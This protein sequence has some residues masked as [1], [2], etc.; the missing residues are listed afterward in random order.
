MKCCIVGAGSVGGH[1]AVKL[2]RAG[3][4]VSVLARG[5]QLAAIRAGGL[6]LEQDGQ[7]LAATVR[8]SD[9][10]AELGAQELVFVTTK[11]T[12]L[13]QVARQLPPLVDGATTVAFLQN[14]M[15]WW[16]PLGLPADLPT[17]PQLPL[18]RLA[19][20]YL[21]VLRPE[22][23]LGG[24][25]YSANEVLRPGVVRN[26]S[27]R[28]NLVELAAIDDRETP[29]VQR[30]RAVLVEAGIASP[31]VDDIRTAL[32]L[33]LVG[34]AS[35]S[36]L[37]VATGNPASLVQDP[38]LKT[39]Y[40]RL[41][42][43]C[44]AVAGASGYP[45]A[46]RMDLALFTQHRGQHKPSMLQDYEAGRP[47]EIEEIILA[48]VHFARAAGIATPTLDAAS[49]ITARLAADRGLFTPG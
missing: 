18:F 23:V 39:V 17:P 16:Y 35:A 46:D 22:Q 9:D 36:S 20:T 44:M 32:W 42:Q 45:V 48:P 34:N 28:R 6:V 14:G 2:Q 40:L 41:L 1:L 19:D 38:A 31:V 27:P 26:N 25:V 24:I 37:C 43:E 3:H 33:K 12:A 47:M 10:P 7:A 30:A 21:T 49:A 13:P 29:A 8:A 4:E 15:T 11:A 5:A